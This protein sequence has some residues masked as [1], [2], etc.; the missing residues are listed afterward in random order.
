MATKQ[1]KTDL[2]C[3][4]EVTSGSLINSQKYH[5]HEFFLLYVHFNYLTGDPVNFLSLK[6]SGVEINLNKEYV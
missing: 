4:I 3:L 5:E 6:H 2:Y 1:K